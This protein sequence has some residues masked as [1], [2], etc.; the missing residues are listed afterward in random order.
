MAECKI[1]KDMQLET[2]H[3]TIRATRVQIGLEMP[4]GNKNNQECSYL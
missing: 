4:A 2:A 1:P 3:N